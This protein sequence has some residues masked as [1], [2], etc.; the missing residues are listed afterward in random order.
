MHTVQK[1]W[2]QIETSISTRLS[3]KDLHTNFQLSRSIK[4]TV[5]DHSNSAN[6]QHIYNFKYFAKNNMLIG[7]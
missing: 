3:F 5:F 4:S 1:Y 2:K 7:T 6:F